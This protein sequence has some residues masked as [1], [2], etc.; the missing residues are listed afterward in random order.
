MD[1]RDLWE[2][3]VQRLTNQCRLML[4]QV[5]AFDE[6]LT[7]LEHTILTLIVALKEGGVIVDSDE[8]EH[9]F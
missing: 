6:R 8:G 7:F 2:E 3:Q 5:T 4:D 1:T 9:Q